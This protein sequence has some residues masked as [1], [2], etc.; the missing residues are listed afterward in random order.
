MVSII[1]KD[2]KKVD[3]EN[4]GVKITTSEDASGEDGT[5]QEENTEE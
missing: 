5:A 2:G 3:F 1:L 4:F